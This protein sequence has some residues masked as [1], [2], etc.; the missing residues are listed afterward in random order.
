MKKLAPFLNLS[1]EVVFAMLRDLVIEEAER[2]PFGLVARDP[3]GESA[4]EAA[5]FRATS[6]QEI[7]AEFT[8]GA[9]G[10]H[11]LPRAPE[12]AMALDRG[13]NPD[14]SQR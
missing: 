12:W 11:G 14:R 7:L 9:D 1:R 6:L 13:D 5:R 3:E 4:R 10:R 2:S 8:R